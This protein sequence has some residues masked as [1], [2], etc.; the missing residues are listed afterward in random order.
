MRDRHRD[1]GVGRPVHDQRTILAPAFRLEPTRI[2]ERNYLGNNIYYPPDGR[3]GD[4]VLLGTKVMIPID[5]PVRE[6]VGLLG[7]PPLKSRAWS[8]TRELIA[9]VDE[10]DRRQRIPPRTATTW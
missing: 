8:R 7:S 3:T 9:G 1:H 10:A 6:N 5:G 4:N 2:G